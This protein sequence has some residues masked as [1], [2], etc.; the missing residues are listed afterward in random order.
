MAQIL[1]TQVS[2][3]AVSTGNQ[4]VGDAALSK[5][6]G[7][8][9][10]LQTASNG[11]ARLVLNGQHIPLPRLTQENRPTQQSQPVK[12]NVREQAT[13]TFLE[14]VK[15]GNTSHSLQLTPTQGKQ[16]LNVIA[17]TP[18][19]LTNYAPGVIEA[20]VLK[21][22][23][24]QLMLQVNGKAISL[25]VANASARFKEGQMVTLRLLAKQDN[26]QLEIKDPNKPST[27]NKLIQPNARQLPDI[28]ATTLPR[29]TSLKLDNQDKATHLN[30]QRILPSSIQGNFKVDMPALPVLNIDKHQQ[31]KMQWS[32]SEQLLAKLPLEGGLKQKAIDAVANTINTLGNNTA[33]TQQ[34]VLTK[35][36]MGR[37]SISQE[38][39]MEMTSSSEKS[40]L[41]ATVRQATIASVDSSK[42]R[43]DLQPLMRGLQ[44]KIDSPSVLINSLEK[45]LSGI[46][47]QADSPIGDYVSE[48]SKLIGNEKLT[49][50]NGQISP[51]ELK[52]LL[53]ASP[54][55]VTP[56]NINTPPPQANF[57]AGIM[58]M[59]QVSLAARLMRQQP[60]HLD[61]LT[62]L[63]SP[64]LMGGTQKTSGKQQVSKGLSDFFQADSKFQILKSLD[65]LISAHQFNKL[66]NMEA[67]LQGQDTLYYVLPMGE[68]GQRKDVELL[69]KREQERESGQE[70]QKIKGTYWALTMK[71]PIGDIGQLLAKAKIA[72]SDLEL[73]FYTSN[74]QTKELVFNFIPVLKKRF[75]Q[76][77]IDIG[78]CACQLGK[79]P[80]ALQQRPYHLFEAR[81]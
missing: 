53:T 32:Q 24:D 4:V 37:V 16:L 8:T 74:E 57:L 30:I 11:S 72:G 45:S 40:T 29:N 79:I 13:Q 55:P 41:Q 14:I 7:Q 71:L 10:L 19:V 54:L 56:S 39:A 67:Q 59:L 27:Q 9:A 34:A 51:Q 17:N 18:S 25:N 20:K 38:L 80:D 5:L 12:L 36:G 62:Q 66:S 50:S 52:Q 48:M 33:V 1:N 78:K 49:Q 70:K 46:I 2:S 81:A 22:N 58:G 28:L 75:E 35:E 68:N 65:K 23:G 26:W 31:L 76:L 63:L 61:K 73:D 3:Q 64:S 77:G 6:Q 47:G 60:E 21:V 15:P 42:I 44:A 43:S 69:I